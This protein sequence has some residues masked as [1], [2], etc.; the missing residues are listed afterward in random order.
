MDFPIG[1]D[2]EGYHTLL[3][4]AILYVEG[5]SQK[6]GQSYNELSS[7]QVDI[8]DLGSATEALIFATDK[9]RDQKIKLE[10]YRTELRKSITSSYEEK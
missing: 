5:L 10:A 7:Q 8:D 9:L 4:E 1:I 3:N 6:L 2:Q